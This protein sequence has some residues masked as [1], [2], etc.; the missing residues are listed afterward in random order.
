VLAGEFAESLR[1]VFGPGYR[2]LRLAL[3]GSILAVLALLVAA[4]EDFTLDTTGQSSAPLPSKEPAV[5]G[6]G[7]ER[8]APGG[9]NPPAIKLP[10]LPAGSNDNTA[11]DLSS[12]HC[13]KVSWLGPD[14]IPPGI[15]IEVTDVDIEPPD[16]FE[17]IPPA[18]GRPIC[19]DPKK[20]FAFDSANRQCYLTVRAMAPDVEAT[21]TMVGSVRCAVAAQASCA[22]FVAD[23][24][25]RAEP[26]NLFGPPAEEDSGPSVEPSTGGGG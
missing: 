25:E 14:I 20:P 26:I 16:S 8:P 11:S 21:L 19:D 15:S 12:P 13:V 24:Q 4:C 23:S 18:C 6:T 9:K 7:P 3:G 5:E 22:S 17:K 10:S 1:R 2:W